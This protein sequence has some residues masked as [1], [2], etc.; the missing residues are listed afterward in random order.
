M[1][2]IRAVHFGFPWWQGAPGT[3]RFS[4]LESWEQLFSVR[5]AGGSEVRRFLSDVI[6]R[7]TIFGFGTPSQ[8]KFWSK[9][10]I[11]KKQSESDAVKQLV[12]IVAKFANSL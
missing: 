2:G 11:E 7:R 12:A 10:A 5:T 4:T 3:A 8:L 9:D 6:A 1:V